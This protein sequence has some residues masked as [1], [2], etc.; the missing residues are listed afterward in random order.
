MEC[1]IPK[2]GMRRPV[3]GGDVVDRIGPSG[4]ANGAGFV[5]MDLDDGTLLLPHQD[6]AS[7]ESVAA[8]VP[9]EQEKPLVGYLE[10]A[11]A[12]WPVVCI[13][14]DM[15]PLTSVPAGRRI[16]LLLRSGERGFG[17]LCDGI[18]MLDAEALR[19]QEL[20]ACMAAS[21]SPLAGLAIQEGKVVSMTS[22]SLLAGFLE[23][24]RFENRS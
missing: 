2:P 6:V 7:I 19:V 8:L 12:R 24:C 3:A 20:P 9:E 23:H 10:L 21:F 17:V 16:C 18:Q 11:N 1:A 13:S 22:A 15:E 4:P 5:S 14:G